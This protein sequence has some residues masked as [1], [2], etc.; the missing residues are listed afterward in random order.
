MNFFDQLKLVDDEIEEI[1]SK[2]GN[3]YENWFSMQDPYLRK[4]VNN[5]IVKLETL[6]DEMIDRRRQ[7]EGVLRLAGMPSNG[8]NTSMLIS[9]LSSKR[10]DC[11]QV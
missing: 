5:C 2:I 9:S 3:L 8:L 1:T 7:L 11:K 4:A 6:E 10:H